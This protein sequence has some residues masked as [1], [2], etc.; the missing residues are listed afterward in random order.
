M[1]TTNVS[2]LRGLHAS[3]PTSGAIDGAFYLTTDSNRLFVGKSDGTLADLNKYINI[4]EKTSDINITTA[5]VG[6]FY[7]V[8]DQNLLV[9]CELDGNSKKFTLI[10]QNTDTTNVTAT[11]AYTVTAENDVATVEYNYSVVDSEDGS[12]SAKDSFTITGGDNINVSASGKNITIDGAEY[13]LKVVTDPAA[14]GEV[15]SVTLQLT[16]SLNPGLTSSATFKAGS[17]VTLSKDSSGNIVIDSSFNNTTIKSISTDLNDDGT[18]SVTIIDSDDTPHTSSKSGVIS[19]GVGEET[20][21]PGS[22]LPVYNKDEID[23]KLNGLN[24]MVYRGTVGAGGTVSSLPTSEV[25]AGDTY[26][27]VGSNEIVG[28]GNT[29]HAGDLFIATGTE[30]ADG[31]LTSITWTY[32][33]SGDEAEHDTQ[34]KFLIDAANN[35][36]KLATTDND[37]SGVHTI[38]VEENGAL[39]ISSTSASEGELTTTISHKKISSITPDE[40]SVSDAESITAITGVTVDDYGHVT[41]YEVTTSAL[42]EYELTGSNTVA[43]NK[44]TFV[45][46][47]L[48]SNDGEKGSVSHEL[49]STSLAIAST[50]NGASIEL[51]WETF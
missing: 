7:Y 5:Q 9:V 29:G 21:L 41:G 10:N 36:I 19:F 39:S 33:P 4:V 30:G 48:D 40:K 25:S 51:I 23:K 8:K 3:L 43:D 37:V 49:S 20:F 12:V 38:A 27:V 42:V 45:T 15:D 47:L 1:A 14:T 44:A 11:A 16:N 46:S 24:A 31:Y 2:F 34:Y 32:V 17:N 50:T 26:L 22:V 28:S 6:D 13:D 18:I 35:A